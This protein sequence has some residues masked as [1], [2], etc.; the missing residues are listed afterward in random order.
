[1]ESSAPAVHLF[2]QSHS[3]SVLHLNHKYIAQCA[4]KL[5][6]RNLIK[7]STSGGP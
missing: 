6:F 3:P 7:I 2:K 1:V 5:L 4:L